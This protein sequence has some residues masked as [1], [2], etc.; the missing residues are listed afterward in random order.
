MSQVMSVA[1]LRL[2]ERGNRLRCL[3]MQELTAGKGLSLLDC[4][5]NCG[6]RIGGQPLH[7]YGRG[8]YVDALLRQ[9]KNQNVDCGARCL[10]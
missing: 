4:S 1:A 2:P 10:S 5:I 8:F 7:G 3:E 9:A 6:P